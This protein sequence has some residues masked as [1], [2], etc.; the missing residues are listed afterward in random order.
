MNGDEDGF[1][2]Y[3][4]LFVI[5]SAT[6][7]AVGSVQR[8]CFRL[9]GVRMSIGA[10]NRLFRGLISQVGQP[11][12]R[13]TTDGCGTNQNGDWGCFVWMFRYILRS[14]CTREERKKRAGWLDRWAGRE[15]GAVYCAKQRT[16]YIPYQGYHHNPV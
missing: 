7:G 3:I 5:L 4:V 9:A 10:R 11:V 14:I 13:P 15:V 1:K 8:L 16:S 2:R 12:G 6:T